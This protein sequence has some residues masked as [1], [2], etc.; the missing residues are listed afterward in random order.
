MERLDFDERV[1]AL[2]AYDPSRRG[3]KQ[4]ALRTKLVV[5][6]GEWLAKFA[7]QALSTLPTEGPAD[8][9]AI[10]LLKR[11]QEAANHL[12]ALAAFPSPD[13]EKV[14][15]N[16]ALRCHALRQLNGAL[17]R[18]SHVV[19]AL[20]LPVE[21]DRNIKVVGGGLQARKVRATRKRRC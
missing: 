8:A 2:R 20:A 4:Q 14:C 3:A 19:A 12:L 9:E 18:T 7:V 5:E 15:Y 17:E 21:W 6:H 1:A 10:Q 11:A 13:P 16:V